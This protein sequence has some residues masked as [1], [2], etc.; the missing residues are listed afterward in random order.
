MEKTAQPRDP[1]S[2]GS[3]GVVAITPGAPP[4]AAIT[5]DTSSPL[6]WLSISQVE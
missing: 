1:W 5:D 3:A 2:E 4:A 6:T